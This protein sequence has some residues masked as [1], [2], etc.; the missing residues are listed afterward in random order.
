MA[1]PTQ[2]SASI[3]GKAA[4]RAIAPTRPS[5][6]TVNTVPDSVTDRSGGP[7]S[8]EGT[9]RPDGDPATLGTPGSSSRRGAWLAGPPVV[10]D[11]TYLIWEE[12]V[13][14]A[15]LTVDVTFAPP[16]M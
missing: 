16:M 6:T 2:A 8:R 1:S 9:G 14:A 3:S 5:R 11:M 10:V 7:D 13:F 12:M 4:Q 15:A